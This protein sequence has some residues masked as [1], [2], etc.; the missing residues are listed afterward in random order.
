M[1]LDFISYSGGP[2]PEELLP[3]TK[4]PVRILWGEKDPWEPINLG[5]AYANFD[6]VDEFVPLPNGGHCPMDGEASYENV[7][8]EILRFMKDIK[9][10]K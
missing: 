2:L 3:Q 1:F 7:N 8:L 5:R 10:K 6:C 4:Q 9:K